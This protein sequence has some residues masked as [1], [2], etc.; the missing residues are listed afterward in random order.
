[1]AGLLTNITGRSHLKRRFPAK[2]S[3]GTWRALHKGAIKVR[4]R[5]C[6]VDGCR[7]SPL[8]IMILSKVE[9]YLGAETSRWRL[10]PAPESRGRPRAQADMPRPNGSAFRPFFDRC[11]Y[12]VISRSAVRIRASERNAPQRSGTHYHRWRGIA[13]GL[14]REISAR[15]APCL[16]VAAP[17]P[18]RYPDPKKATWQ[19]CQ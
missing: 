19:A 12:F 2:G 18:R 17:V 4:G 5:L 1:M 6:R 14:S 15:A 9:A 11:H 10:S 3:R 8:S 7:L 13:A 16:C